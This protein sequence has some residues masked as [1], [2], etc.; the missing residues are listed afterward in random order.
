MEEKETD[1]AIIVTQ[2]E[3]GSEI[4]VFMKS[5]NGERVDAEEVMKILNTL[6]IKGA[7]AELAKHK[8]T[9]HAAPKGVM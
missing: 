8:L 9:T 2:S 6:D 4:T 3:D 5:L 7:M 1:I